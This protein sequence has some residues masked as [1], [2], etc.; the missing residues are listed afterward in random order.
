MTR[1]AHFHEDDYCRIEILPL[2]FWPYCAVQ[3]SDAEAAA[4]QKL[5]PSGPYWEEIN[6]LMEKPRSAASARLPRAGLLRIL[7]LHLP[8]FDRVESGTYSYV[9]PC[10]RTDG[11]GFGSHFAIFFDYSENEIVQHIWLALGRANAQERTAFLNGLTHI[12]Q[13]GSFLL[14]NWAKD[15]LFRLRV[16]TH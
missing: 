4:A 10:V 7:S 15:R 11:F 13:T 12:S 2:E 9:E 6:R 5:D 1:T 16:Q 8:Q 3:M 14:V